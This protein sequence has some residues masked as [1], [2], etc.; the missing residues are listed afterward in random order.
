MHAAAKGGCAGLAAD[1][2]VIMKQVL[3]WD[4][5]VRVFH[6]LLVI[7]FAGAWITGD[8][9]KLK[10]WHLAFGYTAGALI[11]FRI[12]WGLVGTRYARF[13]SFVTS[14]RTA[15]RHGWEL[16]RG[17]QKHHLG[18][19]PLGGWMMLSLMAC[20]VL[21][22]ASGYVLYQEWMEED[23]LHEGLANVA[24]TLVFFHV[25]A[26]IIMSRVEKDNLI[27]SMWT[28]YK[29]TNTETPSVR[30]WLGVAAMLLV[31]AIYFFIEIIRGN[32]PALTQ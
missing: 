26:A 15:L 14:P 24:I 12:L 29:S 10:L 28:G 7:C 18:H 27:K 5:P 11:V 19:N 30:P 17:T 16:I 31:V 22:V 13:S 1:D 25:V 32:F 6:W 2:Q 3:V 8:T 21:L 20:V 9:E 23:D 4:F